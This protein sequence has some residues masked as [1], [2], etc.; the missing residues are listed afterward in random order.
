MFD[1]LNAQV[2]GLVQARPST[3]GWASAISVVLALWSARSGVGALIT[4]LNTIHGTRNRRGLRRYLVALL[5]TLALVG[6]TLVAMAAVVI[7]PIL[8]ALLP[9]GSLTAIVFEIIR[10]CAAIG[11]LMG[12]LTVI[13]RFGPNRPA[14]PPLRWLTPGAILAVSF[15]A[16][17][18]AGFSLYLSNFGNYNQIY[19][20]IGAVVALLMWL[21]LSAFLVLLGA[22]IDAY[23]EAVLAQPRR[24]RKKDDA[25]QPAEMAM[26]SDKSP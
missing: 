14:P 17:A 24:Y 19:G 1:L 2:T 9:L 25:P 12:G 10:W 15:W 13:Y 4:G 7:A 20:S 8:L 26:A 11:V 5:L 6:V 3:L 21:Y 22:L 18:S 16:A 23:F